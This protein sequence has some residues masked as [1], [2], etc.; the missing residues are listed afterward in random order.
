MKLALIALFAVGCTAKPASDDSPATDDSPAVEEPAWPE[1]LAE[2]SELSSG[3]CPDM[4]ASGTVSF[5]SSG[6]A[7]TVTVVRP[8][9]V[10]SDTAV[11]VFFH[12]L[13][14]PSQTPNPTEYMA[15]GLG[16]QD[17]ADDNNVIVLLPESG[18]RTE[19]GQ[20]FYLFDVEGTSD[21]DIVLYDDLRTCVAALEPNMAR[22]SAMGFSGGALFTT[23]IAS[24]RGDTLAS[25]VEMSGGADLDVVISESTVAAYSTPAYDFPALLAS[26]GSTDRWPSPSIAIVDFEAGSDTL[27][28]HLVSDGHLVVRCHHDQGHTITNAEFALAQQ[29]VLQHTFGQPSPWASG[30]LGSDSSW[31]A[32]GVAE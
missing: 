8:D 31:C 12:G 29:W 7:R 21:H 22:M 24:Q 20:T 13:M 25:I 11:V 32:M 26:G 17:L 19:F 4:S 15:E 23:L 30:D 5:T 6:E 1:G 16:L 9:V 2:L 27:E 10:D 3:E 28:H 14:S 18:Q